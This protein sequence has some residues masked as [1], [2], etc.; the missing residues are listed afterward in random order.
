MGGDYGERMEG[1]Q[2]GVCRSIEQGGDRKIPTTHLHLSFRNSI[3]VSWVDKIRVH[4]Y[5]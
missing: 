5:M 3:K 2:R 1:G 4:V